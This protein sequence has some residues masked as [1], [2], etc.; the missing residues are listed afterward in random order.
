MAAVKEQRNNERER[1][2][3]SEKD[4]RSRRSRLFTLARARYQGRWLPGL[5]K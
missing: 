5:Q 1:A 3:T 2:G 4:E